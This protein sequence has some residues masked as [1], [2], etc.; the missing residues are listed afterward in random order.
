M[1]QY[2]KTGS[3]LFLALFALDVFSLRA[4]EES[5]EALK[6]QAEISQAK[7]QNIALSKVPNGEIKS[8][9]IEKENSRLVWSFDIA[10]PHSKNITEV[11]VDAK[12]SEIVLVEIETP[13]QQMQEIKADNE[14]NK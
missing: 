13:E 11:Q 3:I 12:T 5:Q 10:V 9:E 14:G 2:L 1:K 4:G 8:V 7:A 6:A